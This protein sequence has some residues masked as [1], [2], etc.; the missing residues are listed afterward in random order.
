MT[1][2][3]W[4]DEA[5]EFIIH[6]YG[7]SSGDFRSFQDA[8]VEFIRNL[9]SKAKAEG[10]HDAFMEYQSH[11]FY[12]ETVEKSR[13]EGREE[14]EALANK[15]LDGME[16]GITQGEVTL[17]ESGPTIGTWKVLDEAEIRAEETQRIRKLIESMFREPMSQEVQDLLMDES[18]AELDRALGEYNGWNSALKRIL[19]KLTEERE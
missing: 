13:A 4:V 8:H 2:E 7:F 6:A 9:L 14:G 3:S 1:K 15:I 5:D 16:K 12:V 17:R 10:H 19:S 18:G 11:P